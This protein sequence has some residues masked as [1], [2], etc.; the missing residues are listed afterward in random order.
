MRRKTARRTLATNG[1]DQLTQAADGRRPRRRRRRAVAISSSPA[2]DEL[3]IERLQVWMTTDTA[4]AGV[5]APAF[6]AIPPRRGR[7]SEPLTTVR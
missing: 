3:W 1:N 7:C 2:M 5:C 4:R 6:P